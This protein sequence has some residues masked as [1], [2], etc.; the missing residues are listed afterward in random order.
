[1]EKAEVVKLMLDQFLADNNEMAK[2]AGMSEEEVQQLTEKSVPGISYMLENIYD[3]LVQ[4]G[5]I[6]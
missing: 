4:E 2:N 3:K 6:K 5:L 1:M